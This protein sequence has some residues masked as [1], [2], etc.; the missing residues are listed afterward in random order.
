MVCTRSAA[1]ARARHAQALLRGQ[2]RV[3]AACAA[4]HA[5]G[6]VF[7]AAPH[8]LSAVVVEEVR[9]RVDTAR[10]AMAAFETLLH[11]GPPG[12]TPPG[13]VQTELDRL[14]GVAHLQLSRLNALEYAMRAYG[15]WRECVRC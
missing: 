9:Y 11:H 7:D 10:A 5:E 2:Q 3:V 14:Q 12:T 13:T 6:W 4:V 1:E 15:M 8:E